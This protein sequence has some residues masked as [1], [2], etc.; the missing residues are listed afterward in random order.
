MGLIHGNMTM[1]SMFRPILLCLS[2]FIHTSFAWGTLGHEMI[3]N[4][5]WHRLSPSAK[6][7]VQEILHVVEMSGDDDNSPLGKV[8]DWADQVRH[9]MGWS[10]PLHFID[11]RDD[12]I[13]GCYSNKDGCHFQYERDCP[14]DVCVAGAILN[15][16]KQLYQTDLSSSSL[17]SS[18]SYA[19]RGS[20]RSTVFNVTQSLM[21]LTQ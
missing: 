5:A 16:T 18:S 11:I 9:W 6:S 4:L 12:Q 13:G 1:R 3:G 14:N 10:S 8:A 15:Y 21:F 2:L 19:L 17:P 20:S 7:W